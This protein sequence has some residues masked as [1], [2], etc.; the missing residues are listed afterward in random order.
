MTYSSPVVVDGAVVVACHV[1]TEADPDFELASS[2]VALEARTGNERWIASGFE[3]DTRMETPPFAPSP[4]VTDD[5]VRVVTPEGYLAY[6]FDGEERSR[7]TWGDEETSPFELAVPTA[8]E[9]SLCA[10]SSRGVFALDVDGGLEWEFGFDDEGWSENPAI[11]VAVD[12][13]TLYVPA[14]A[15]LYAV[16]AGDGSKRWH[17]SFGTETSPYSPVAGNDRVYV[18]T[19]DHDDLS[20]GALHALDPDDGEVQWE[21]EPDGGSGGIFGSPAWNGS[22]LYATGVAAGEFT[23][24]AIDTG[25]ELEWTTG[26]EAIDPSP[27]VA[28][29]VVYVRDA[30]RTDAVTAYDAANGT[31]VA[32]GA[33]R[34]AA[35][36]PAVAAGQY[37]YATDDGVVA[38]TE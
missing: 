11:T 1:V 15:S 37:Y 34:S 38:M 2:L 24:F 18:T 16:D 31:Q 7:T 36:P 23:L 25:G 21:Y 19:G 28:D 4:V 14:E 9:E 33:L 6:D 12:D 26:V 13:E 5:T 30:V 29:G 10:P 3:T 35:A 8:T 32:E 22:L 27:V 17:R 20:G